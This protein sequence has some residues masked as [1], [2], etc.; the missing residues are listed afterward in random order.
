MFCVLVRYGLYVNKT[1]EGQMFIPKKSHAFITCLT[2]LPKL[3]LFQSENE[4][5]SKIVNLRVLACDTFILV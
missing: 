4:D 2:M 5:F 1:S 3:T